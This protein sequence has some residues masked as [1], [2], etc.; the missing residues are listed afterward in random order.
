MEPQLRVTITT[1]LE[2][3]VSQREI[4]RR[5]GVDRKTIRRYARLA[6]SSTPAT[7]LPEP[8]AQTP[9]PWPPAPVALEAAPPGSPASCV[10]ACSENEECYEGVCVPSVDTV[11]VQDV[12]NG[13]IPGC[14]TG[15]PSYTLT[16]LVV[17]AVD[18]LGADD[19]TFYVM[20]PAGGPFSG[21]LVT[22]MG[23]AEITGDVV[24]GATVDL[25]TEVRQNSK[26]TNLRATMVTVTGA[27]TVPAPA[28]VDP[29]DVATG[30]ALAETYEGMLVQVVNVAVTTENPDDPDDY[31]EFEVG[32]ALRI[33]DEL[34]AYTRP[35]AGAC[36]ATL[37]GVL[38]FSFGNFKILP[39]DAD[40]M[41]T[42]ELCE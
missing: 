29:A 21:A 41:V 24:L 18:D 26:G 2:R 36:F 37:T 5:T 40:D 17:V 20:D 28:V 1:L 15:C 9:P 27:G 16:G 33:D 4:E 7:G 42:G 19:T 30:G 8:R 31:N 35:A 34:F 25:V 3:G 12:Q 11:T 38:R 32:G 13:T 10:S 14:S 6:K 23:S 39:R 22:P